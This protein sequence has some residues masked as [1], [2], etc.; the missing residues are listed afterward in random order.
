[1]PNNRSD[2]SHG[3]V[4]I[5]WFWIRNQLT[6]NLAFGY[7]I[8]RELNVREVPFPEA[9]SLEFVRANSF[10]NKAIGIGHYNK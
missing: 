8:Y 9:I 7:S 3:I 5:D 6:T 10:Q 2:F 1:M 4:I